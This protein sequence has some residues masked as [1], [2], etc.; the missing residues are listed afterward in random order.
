MSKD[1][2]F[3]GRNES[4]KLG[5]LLLT[6]SLFLPYLVNYRGPESLLGTFM[7]YAP[8]WVLQQRL[9]ILYGGPSIMALAMF[10]FWIPYVLIGFQ[11]YR[12]ASGQLSSERSYLRSVIVLTAIAVLL[13]LPFSLM[14]SGSDGD[15]DFYY[16]YIPIPLI[17]ILA[18]ASY[19]R[20]LPK[21]VETPWVEDSEEESVWTD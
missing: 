5:Q 11:A 2:P 19:R 9:G 6:L 8:I 7:I 17:P 10:Q 14:P 15:T 13:V 20:L 12:Y 21:R 18:L 3:V 16:P 4:V 1:N